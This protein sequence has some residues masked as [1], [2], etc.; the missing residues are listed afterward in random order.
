M[1]TS[2]LGAADT[3]TGSRQLLQLGGTG[4][5]LDR[6]L[7][8]GDKT[9]R[10]RNWLP[11]SAELL[12][13]DAL[14][15]SHAH[16]DHTGWLPAL[17]KAGKRGKVYASPTT[18]DLGA[19]IGKTIHRGG[20]VLLPSFAVGRAQV[21]MLVLQR[22]KAGGQIPHDLPFFLGSPMA[23]R[24]TERC[25][26]HRHCHRQMLRVLRHLKQM[27]PDTRHHVV[28]AGFHVGGG[29]GARLVAVETEVK[30]HREYVTVKAEIS[31]LEGCSGHADCGELMDWLRGFKEQ[32]RQT[33]VV[34]GEPGASAALAHPGR[35]G[36]G[37][38]GGADA[39]T[40]MDP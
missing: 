11:P 33:F 32:P 34:H 17:A 40:A 21:L 6:G 31:Q 3:V 1:R 35:T 13:V 4:N 12:N 5:L 10:E 22:L 19:I 20:W 8:Q 39:S 14:V 25:Q 23:I 2:F 38:A 26:R 7:Y 18:R 28:F 37:C 30:I 29:Q 27:A 15:L 36:L 16:L 24:A 9:F